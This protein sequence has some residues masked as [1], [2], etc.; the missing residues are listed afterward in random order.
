[1]NVLWVISALAGSL[2]FPF[3]DGSLRQQRAFTDF[4]SQF[5]KTYKSEDEKN[6]RFA[7]FKQNLDK[8]ENHNIKPGVSWQMGVNK[9]T[10]MTGKHFLHSL[11]LKDIVKFLE[12]WFLEINIVLQ[13]TSIFKTILILFVFVI[14]QT[15][16]KPF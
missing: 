16:L 6:E 10:D 3:V 9:F 7:I 13:R 14:I 1:M 11:M 2:S 4:Q 15:E 5:A 12:N 8:I